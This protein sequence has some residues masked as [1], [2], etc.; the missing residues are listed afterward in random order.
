M[1]TDFED[2]KKKFSKSNGKTDVLDNFC[3]DITKLARTNM[4]DTVIGREKEVK[5]LC[6][7]L[8]RRVKSNAVLIGIAGVGKTAI[9][10][11]LAQMIVDGKAPKILSD[12]KIY[13][14]DLGLV[15]AGT[16]Y[17]GQFEERIKAIIDEL[18][19]NRNIII[20]IDEL[21]VM[22]G[23]GNASGSLDASNMLK[24]AL[25]RGEI[26]IVGATTLDEYRE[27]I[28]KDHGLSRRFQSILIEEPTVEETKEILMN[29]K[30]KFEDY[31]GVEYTNEAID[32]CVK[33]SQRYITDRALPDKAID[34]MDDAGASINVSF[35][36][37]SEIAVLEAKRNDCL[38]KKKEYIARQDYEK[39]QDVK[40]EESILNREIIEIKKKW[41]KE[42]EKKKNIVDKD[43]IE[44]I[45]SQTT[46]I[47][48]NKISSKENKKLLDIE[49]ELS[50]KVIGQDEA[51]SKIGKAI[52]R[53]RLGIKDKNKPISFMLLGSSGIGK[54]VTDNTFITIKNK[55]TDVIQK[56]TI[57]KFFNKIKLI[58]KNKKK[59]NDNETRI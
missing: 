20:F 37:P 42:I 21:H 2:D 23:A 16:K 11:K 58:N 53:S 33:L 46:G 1:D 43:I 35:E 31:H 28:E 29:I 6:Q 39:A 3:K 56:I 24:P 47:P 38:V 57:G 4:L 34:V 12:K 49:K 25:A 40:T 41:E 19:N 10:N 44:E 17:R 30:Y 51:V 26:Q 18:S 9:I 52:K 5:K 48:V 32:E 55:N 14:L 15:V 22:V 59:N 8:S 7:V 54:C 50:L 36:I 45:I 13:S 27:H